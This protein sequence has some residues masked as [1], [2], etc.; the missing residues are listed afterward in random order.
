MENNALL[1]DATQRVSAE[2]EGNPHPCLWK[3]F[4]QNILVDETLKGN[5]GKKKKT[6]KFTYLQATCIL[7][8]L[9]LA[10]L[11]FQE[12]KEFLSMQANEK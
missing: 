3:R 8:E 6:C 10:I 7:A 9:F 12:G 11:E 2:Q 5:L 1:L 4:N